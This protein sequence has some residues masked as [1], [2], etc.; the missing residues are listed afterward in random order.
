MDPVTLVFYA[1]VC[2]C[3][4]WA[5]PKLGAP[6]IRFGIGAAVGLVAATLLP[7]ARAAL[8]LGY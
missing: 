8:G 7:M 3:L 1:L 4:S 2:A 5:A 6:W